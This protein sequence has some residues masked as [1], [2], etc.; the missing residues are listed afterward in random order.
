MGRLF[1]A[2]NENQG[3]N[4]MEAAIKDTIGPVVTSSEIDEES[5]KTIDY[6]HAVLRKQQE[7]FLNEGPVSL[8]VRL[9]RLERVMKMVYENKDDIVQACNR[10][11]G[12]RSLYQ[13]QMSE[14]MAVLDA[15]R[16]AKK[17]VKKWMKAE[18]RKPMFPLGLMGAKAHV[19]Y[20]PKGV[21]GNISTWNFPVNVALS[22]V[23]GILAAGNRCMIKMSEITPE[24]SA[25]LTKLI[26]KYFDET[27][28]VAINGGPEVGAAFSALPFDHVIFTGATGI[29]RHILRAA[30]DNLT[31]VTLELGGKSPVIVTRNYDLQK[32]AER[33]IT[34][35]S[36][37][38]GQVCLS[39]DYCFIPKDQM[40]AF[41]E[42]ASKH[43]ADMFPSILENQDVT[44][45]VNSRHHERLQGLI[46]DA[47]V[48]GAD[49][50]EL[51]PAN[52]DFSKQ[53]EG[54][55]KLPLTLIINPTDDMRVMQEEI[56]GPVLCL[57][58]YDNISDCLQFINARPRPL[59]LYLFSDDK[60]EQTMVASKT[61]SG[62][63][64]IN[65][66]LAH[67]SC[68]DLPFGG[69]G[70]SGMGHYH[71]FDGFQ[72]FSHKKAIYKQ[73]SI[74]LMKLSNMM[75]PYGEKCQKQLDNLI[76]PN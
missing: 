45:V 48:K 34:G 36:L 52:E 31:P 50:R 13:S 51:N 67:A 47:R 21:V 66:V 8:E 62:G 26:G 27:E 55:N 29:G 25:L 44:S 70:P 19:E 33:V 71:G 63:M 17:N 14:I 69:I 20:Q 57:K 2:S 30:A 59:G 18:K 32:A 46:D 42:H 41:V 68:D 76:K 56:F 38:M 40:E 22:P 4:T 5:Q 64:A 60:A 54:V 37:N 74:N 23:A 65:D 75:P 9:D 11:F 73:T 43:F 61:I 39:P 6:M 72:T 15:F 28:L 10:D 35:K 7:A 53:K 1:M 58:S 16:E 24:T 3:R 12:N 49:V